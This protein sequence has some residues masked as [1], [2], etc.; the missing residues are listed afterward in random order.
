M[1]KDTNYKIMTVDEDNKPLATYKENGEMWVD[2]ERLDEAKKRI[3]ELLSDMVDKKN[4][5]LKLK[6]F[7]FEAKREE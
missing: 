5:V 2:K 3:T 1:T 4:D 7:I 6:D